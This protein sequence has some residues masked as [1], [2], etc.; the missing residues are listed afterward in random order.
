[1]NILERIAS[2]AGLDVS[3]VP[4]PEIVE[5]RTL[6]DEGRQR[7]RTESYDEAL[8]LFDQAA[9]MTQALKDRSSRSIIELHRADIYIRQARWEEAEA[10]LDELAQE[11]RTAKEPIQSAYTQITRGT[12][13]Q[14]RGN[15]DKAR[16]D[17][18]EGAKLAREAHS[19]GAEGRAAGHLGD[20]YLQE[21]NAS[22]AVHLLRDALVKLNS[23]SDME[24]SSYFAGRLGQALLE[25]GQTIE[26][27]QMLSRALRLAQ[28]MNYRIFERIWHIA[29]G[30]RAFESGRYA[31]AFR[32]YERALLMLRSNAPESID[33]LR[34]LSKI[35]L[36]LEK[37]DEAQ[38]YAQ[39]ALD[40]DPANLI[41]RGNLGLITSL[42][43][44]PAEALPDLR[45][46]VEYGEA[47]P[48]PAHAEYMRA[49]AG[50]LSE[51]NETVEA[52]AMYDRALK[53]ARQQANRLEEARALRD[54]GMFYA[55]HRDNPAALKMWSEAIPI[56]ES[57]NHM[58][59][60]ARLYCDIANIRVSMGA[61]QRAMKDYEQALMAL[62]S[63]QDYETRG[64]VLA[65][66]AIAYVDLGD[67]DTA[68]SFLSESIRIAEKLQDRASE[69]TRRG[70]YGWFLLITGRLQ[71]ALMTL[72]L[73]QQQSRSLGLKVPLAVQT[74]NLALVYAEMGQIERAIS[75]H[76]EAIAMLETLDA[77]YWLATAQYNLAQI[78]LKQNDIDAA[79]ALMDAVQATAERLQHYELR[80]RAQIG[81]ARVAAIR[82]EHDRAGTLLQEALLAARRL[83]ARRLI[84][85]AL[86]VSSEHQA[87]QGQIERAAQVWEEARKQYEVLH[88][89]LAKQTPHWLPTT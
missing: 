6:I 89:P 4:R 88:H 83:N 87:Q 67:I 29:L 19:A 74:D 73:A 49:L 21:G 65:N 32:Q 51:T 43:G 76:E 20:I 48:H 47:H 45:A 44:K 64:I 7:K 46:V 9:E 82:G 28:H 40:A 15:L 53:A 37:F 39:R 1:M 31:E 25:T 35:S 18:E 68:D 26:G 13:E 81:Q 10:V 34:E 22:Y 54:I 36:H 14:A 77:P 27:E 17:Y 60:V 38:Q 56:F 70:N 3:N 5:L 78:R 50:A 86:L 75:G 2:L 11:A 8:R 41:N 62:N 80:I 24:L 72:E 33:V 30:K 52:A 85:E 69:A 12:L 66:A 55:R 16:A 71:R 61:S 57:L 63:V 59:Q 58:S 79:A 42:M 23:S 84:A